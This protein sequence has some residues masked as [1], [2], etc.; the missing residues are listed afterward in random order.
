MK[1]VIRYVFLLGLLFVGKYGYMQAH[2]AAAGAGAH[3][4]PVI[5]EKSILK[6]I[7]ISTESDD[8]LPSDK[9]KQAN[10][11]LHFLSSYAQPVKL[12]NYQFHSCLPF[13]KPLVQSFPD[14]Y[15]LY[16]VFRI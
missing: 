1:L 2:A 9:K 16:G 6:A 8:E 5:K 3:V 10:P 12:F 14:K 15:I 13:S 4:A 11:G 7:Q